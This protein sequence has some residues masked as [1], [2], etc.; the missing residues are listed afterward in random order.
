MIVGYSMV[1]SIWDDAKRC[2]KDLGRLVI[3]NR[4]VMRPRREKICPLSMSRAHMIQ[5]WGWFEGALY[6]WLSLVPDVSW[7]FTALLSFHYRDFRA[8]FC[9]PMVKW[10]QEKSVL[11]QGDAYTSS[12]EKHERI[13][14]ELTGVLWV[15][16]ERRPKIDQT[17]EA[18]Q[19]FRHWMRNRMCPDCRPY[20]N[21]PFIFLA[22]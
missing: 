8:V 21:L 6:P 12:N 22:A 20:E 17:A 19:G 3:W 13:M 9:A 7:G 14:N 5:P 15:P 2:K 4:F 18:Y 10:R 16:V 1:H 11:D